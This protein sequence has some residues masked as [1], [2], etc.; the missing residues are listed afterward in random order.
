MRF[1]YSR[2]ALRCAGIAE[3]ASNGWLPSHAYLALD[4]L[5]AAVSRIDDAAITAGRDP[6]TIRKVYNI[7]RVI[8]PGSAGAFRGPAAQWI[9][10]LVNLVRTA[11]MNGFVL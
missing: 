11:G 5:P 4:A 7:A 10:H 1:A 3:A 2:R 6:G 8:Q 9:E